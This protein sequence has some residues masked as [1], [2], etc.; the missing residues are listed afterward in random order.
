MVM[1]SAIVKTAT[2]LVLAKGFSTIMGMLSSSPKWG[3]YAPDG[4]PFMSV[5]GSSSLL[6]SLLGG[7]SNSTLST[8]SVDFSADARAADFPVA[9]NSVTT[10]ATSVSF[11]SF[12]KVESPFMVRVQLRL[13]GTVAEKTQL[14]IKL[15]NSRKNTSIWNIFTPELQM[16]NC[17]LESYSYSR[18]ADSGMTMLKI[19][20]VWRKIRTV[21]ATYAKTT[22]STAAT[23]APS[24]SAKVGSSATSAGS[25]ASKALGAVQAKVPGAS[26]IKGASNYLS[27]KGYALGK[28][29]AGYLK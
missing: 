17:T 25:L 1:G 21:T 12:N 14:L 27:G 10:T 28:S 4:T 20:T 8:G 18:G 3:V 24:N 22:T 19:D 29:L 15:E 13:N 7:G 9:A 11:A 2:K 6:V 23:P 5:G 26:I 16:T